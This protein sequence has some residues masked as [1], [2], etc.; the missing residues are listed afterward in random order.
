MVE[1][2][3]QVGQADGMSLHPI[4][5]VTVRL[6][7][8]DKQFE[9]PFIVFQNLQLPLLFGMDFTQNYIIGIDWD[10]NGA[11]YLRH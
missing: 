10:C 2:Q 6:E 4:G 7:I 11:S 9:H 1:M 8:N 5:I 3:L